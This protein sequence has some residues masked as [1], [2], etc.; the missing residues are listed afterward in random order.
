MAF[1]I[2]LAKI[3]VK[4]QRPRLII[5]A[6]G[7]IIQRVSAIDL[8]LAR[9]EQVEV[10]AV[11]DKDNLSVGQANFLGADACVSGWL[12]P[13]CWIQQKRDEMTDTSTLANLSIILNGEARRVAI[14]MSVADLVAD[15]GLPIKKVAVERNLEIVPRSTLADVML[16]DGD[17]LEIVHFVG[18]G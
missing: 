3:Y 1:M 13:I 8:R 2:G 12:L 6:P 17:T 16:A 14:G 4:A 11:E 7:Y 10:W 18:G 15:L 5:Q 9:A